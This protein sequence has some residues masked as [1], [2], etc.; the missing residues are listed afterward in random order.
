MLGNLLPLGRRQRPH[1]R[2]GEDG[3]R[4]AAGGAHEAQGAGRPGST[5]QMI[6]PPLP[7][8]SQVT[9]QVTDLPGSSP[10]PGAAL[11]RERGERLGPADPDG[12]GRRGPGGPA[13]TDEAPQGQRAEGGGLGAVQHRRRTLQANSTAHHLRPAAPS[14][15]AAEERE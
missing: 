8:P 10:D 13:P 1:R 15:G 9:P 14:G 5:S 3:H 4:V 2:G 12:R 6:L 11:H 7:V